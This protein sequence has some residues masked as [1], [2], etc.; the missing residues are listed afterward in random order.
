MEF[1]REILEQQYGEE[2]AG[3]IFSGL[4]CNRAVTLRANLLKSSAEEIAQALVSAGIEFE[5]AAWSREA[6]VLKNARESAV[7]ELPEYREGKI[8]LQS[9]SSMLPPIVLNPQAGEDILDMAAAP[10][11]KTTQLAALSA[12]KAH[13][14]ACERNKIRAEKL[15]FNLARQGANSVYVMVQDARRLDNFLSFDKVLLDAPC[16][17]S[18]T[19]NLSGG[20]LPEGFTEEFVSKS[21][22]LQLSMLKKAAGLVKKGGELVYSTCSMLESENEDNVLKILDSG[23]E[24]VPF[25]FEG[26]ETIPCLPSKISGALCVKP[27]EFYEGFFVCKMRKI[28]A[29]R[30]IKC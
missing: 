27:T 22:A 24:I 13:V 28:Q 21:A 5:N 29:G 10:G 17:G 15:K 6:F 30:G 25:S 1:L 9:L 2:T 7:W 23:F 8:Y 16:S 18:G 3:E 14:T 4:S 11:G 12:N 19:L 20:K 26:M